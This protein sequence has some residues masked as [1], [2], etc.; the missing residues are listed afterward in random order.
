MAERTAGAQGVELKVTVSN[1]KEGAAAEAFDLD[2]KKGEQRRI[3]FFDTSALALFKRG[4]V[5]R[6]REV[7]GDRDDSTVKVRPVDPKE[8]ASKWVRL[9]G[10]KI[11]AD[12]VGDRMIRSASLSV[13]QRGGEIKAV[14]QKVRAIKKLFSDEQE[15]FI[16]EMSPQQVDFGALKVL[17]PVD[18]RRWK[19][20][21][22]GLPYPIVAEE[23][24][25]PDG[26]DLLEVSIKVPTA[27]AAAASAAFDRFL[28]GL[29]LQPRGGQETKTRVALEYFVKA[30]SV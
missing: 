22:D 18:A 25:L 26:H 3:F 20:E 6:A 12:G 19:V 1:E 5:L 24:T 4:L 2:P 23:W 30:A 10:F 21:H 9:P 14:Q 29:R 15:A 27:Q 7:K 13:E 8:I 16:A 28:R 17:G 11:E